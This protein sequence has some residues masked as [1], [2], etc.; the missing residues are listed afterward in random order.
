MFYWQKYFLV[1]KNKIPEGLLYQQEIWCQHKVQEAF[2]NSEL[3]V[4]RT[5]TYISCFEKRNF[6]KMLTTDDLINIYFKNIN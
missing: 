3:Y 4:C 5:K 6:N 1:K 2:A